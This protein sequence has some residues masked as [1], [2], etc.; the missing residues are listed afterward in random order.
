MKYS[1]QVSG[2]ESTLSI[3]KEGIRI[4]SRFLDFAEVRSLRPVNH[5]VYI[6]TLSGEN[7]EISMLGFSF[8]GFWEE[9]T[10]CFG[11][12]SLESLFTQEQP[13]M[14]CDDGEYRIP[15]EQGRGVIVLLPDAICVLPPS[16]RAIRI[17]LCFTRQLSL[18]NYMFSITMRSGTQYAVG[19]MGYDTMPF[20]ERAQKAAEKVKKQRSQAVSKLKLQP[21]F[22]VTGLFRTNSPEQYWQAAF[23]PGCCAVELFTGENSATYLYRFE[24]PEEHFLMNLEEAMEAMGVNREIINLT[25]EQLAEKPLYRMSVERSEAVRFLRSKACGR[26]IHNASHEQRLAEFLGR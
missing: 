4:G 10:D 24:E 8:D 19:R 2:R 17:P 12:R 21:P 7:I 11:K 22:T 23:G 1:G 14:R 25:A 6:E 5:R 3:E 15:G 13:V 16:Y 20:A 9:L 26:L 18:E